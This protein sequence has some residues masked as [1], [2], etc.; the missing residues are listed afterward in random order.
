MVALA[1]AWESLGVTLDAVAGHSQGEIAAAVVAGILTIEDAAKIVAV[2][3][4][5][6]AG[7]PAGG[8][9]AAVAWSPERAEQAVSGQAV[10]GRVWVAAVNG[11]GSVVLAGDR[12]LLAQ[13]LDQAEAEG[14]RTRWLPVSYASHGPGVDAVAAGLARD[15]AGLTSSA[16]RIPFWSAVTGEV[17]D[18]ERLDGA[19]WVANLRQ[20]VRF[21]DVIQGLEQA[22]HGVFAEIS[23]HPVLTT[24]IEQT[25]TSAGRQDPVVAGTLRRD[26]GGPGRLLASAAELFVRGVSVD[27]T[28]VFDAGAARR[29]PLPTYAFQRQ[30]YWPAARPGAGDVPA[31]GLTATGHPLLAAMMTVAGEAGALFTGHWSVAA[32]PWLGDHMVFGTVLVPGTALLEAVAWVGAAAGCPVVE[33]LVLETPLVLPADGGAQV[34]LRIGGAD[35]DGRRTVSLYSRTGQDDADEWIRHAS[36]TL[37]SEDH[38]RADLAQ[39]AREAGLAGQWPPAGATPVPVEGWYDRLAESG[40]VYGPVFRGLTALWRRGDE[41]FAEARLPAEQHALGYTVHPALLDAAQHAAGLITAG[42]DG[43]VPFS[44]TGTRMTGQAGGELRVRLRPAGDRAVDIVAAGPGGE[45]VVVADRLALRP[46]SADQL[47]AIRPDGRDGLFGVEWVPV[48]GTA[49]GG[50]PVA[51]LGGDS[52]VAA[53]LAAG[54]GWR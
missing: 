7:L 17:T 24:A 28:R 22:G 43:L 16:G 5:A 38:G 18:G 25:L 36:G 39:L 37:V 50:G 10:A 3:A 53:G 21:A 49:A 52:A 6:L 32:L 29:I 12:D 33:E 48:T 1:A 30:R 13:I 23:P 4:R 35:Q 20:Q 27:W 26:D 14:V 47:R 9:M 45:I 46:V 11:P 15:L 42:S 2:R 54:L 41:V 19:Y 51:V 34:Q 8:A 44:W 31:A 40:Y